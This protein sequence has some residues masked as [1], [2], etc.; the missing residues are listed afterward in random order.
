[1]RE[2]QTALASLM[3]TIPVQAGIWQPTAEHQKAPSQ[4][5]VYSTTTTESRHADNGCIEEHT[6]VYMNLWSQ[7][8]PSATAQ[9]VRT[10][11]RAANFAM[12]E[13]SDKGYNQ[14]AYDYKTR[15]FTVQWTWVYRR[16]YDANTI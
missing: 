3:P 11:M 8:D 4:Y 16:C 10:L 9:R 1:M 15:G 6:F 13:E 7:T 14:P 5:I 2:V 12:E